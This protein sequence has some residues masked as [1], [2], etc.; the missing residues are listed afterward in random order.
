M[1][2][3]N[4]TFGK[5]DAYTELSHYP[6][7]ID[8]GFFNEPGYI[9][10]I[11]NHEY[12]FVV[13]D[14]G[15]GKSEIACKFVRMAEQQD[16]LFVNIIDL[17]EF[18]FKQFP[19]FIPN[20]EIETRRRENWKFLLL[21]ALLGSFEKDIGVKTPGPYELNEFI[22]ILN[23]LGIP[24]RT[25]FD[26]KQFGEIVKRTTK[27]GFSVKIPTILEGFHSVE[28]EEEFK[29]NAN[30]F[31]YNLASNCV[32][33]IETPSKHLIIFDGF[34]SILNQVEKQLEHTFK[35]L[36][37]LII[38]SKDLNDSLKRANINAKIVILCRLDLLNK[39]WD[40]NINKI[41]Q[42]SII[43]LDWYSTDLKNSN[44]IKLVN[45]RAEISLGR[46][47]NVV[48]EFFPST[49]GN[50]EAIKMLFELTRHRPRDFIELMNYIKKHAHS[51][52]K[53]KIS[54]ASFWAGVADYS[55]SY[56]RFEIE[57]G[58]VGFS[59]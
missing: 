45:L 3:K 48:E 40:S 16:N 51:D 56:F 34:D 57:N 11:L 44:L 46:K 47:V 50:K 58:L 18:P 4:I 7:L 15:S 10:D 5:A 37:S 41:Y 12:F 24:P 9:N 14:K 26:E 28:K 39:F 8:Q 35:N 36:S 52:D 17:D 53:K 2:F 49:L 54:P 1:D 25:C 20:T 32:F 21:L 33:S 27:S 6:Y 22:E 38:A 30:R 55:R 43:P 31:L 23:K 42:D 29:Q 19:H 13:G 59:R